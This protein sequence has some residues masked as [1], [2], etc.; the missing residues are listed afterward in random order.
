MV[1]TD[2]SGEGESEGGEEKGVTKDSFFEMKKRSPSALH[3]TP[4]MIR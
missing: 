4:F 1:V 3:I 2:G